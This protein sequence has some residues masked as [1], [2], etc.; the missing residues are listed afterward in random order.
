VIERPSPL[1]LR[2]RL[3]SDV[4]QAPLFGLSTIAFG[5]LSIASSLVDK[6]GRAQHAIARTWAKTVVALSLSSVEVVGGENLRKAPVGVYVCNH[7]SY[8]DTPI[9]Y[10]SL[11]FQF[12]ILAKQ[13]LWK[14][15]FIGWHL[16][17]SGQIPIDISTQR[18]SIASLSAG[19]RALKGGLPLVVFPEGGRTSD[20]HP[21]SFQSGAAYLAIKAQ[22]PLVPMAL[23]DAFGLLPIHTRQLHPRPVQLVVGEPISTEGITTRQMNDLNGRVR[24]EVCR[25][26]YE[27]GGIDRPDANGEEA[28]ASDSST[29]EQTR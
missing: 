26:Y 3:F 4:V 7:T 8:M 21:Q 14:I 16:N 29:Y 17:R 11:P 2:Y 6:D 20:G 27:N 10:S 13:E 22:V 24:E 25:L 5:S 1:P 23:V 12:R 18:S 15:P 28:A 19:V 9:L